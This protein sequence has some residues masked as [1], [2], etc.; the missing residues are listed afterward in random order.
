MKDFARSGDSI[1]EVA[2]RHGVARST[3]GTW[4]AGLRIDEELTGGRWVRDGLIMRWQSFLQP[5]R[6]D[7]DDRARRV[8]WEDSMFDDDEARDCHR[9]YAGGWRTDRVMVGE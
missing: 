1:A 6:P 2:A 3:L 5:T 7:I 4:T 8:E 9:L